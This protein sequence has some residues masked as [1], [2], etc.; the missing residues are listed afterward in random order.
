MAALHDYLRFDY[1]PGMHHQLHWQRT[2]TPN[3]QHARL[4]VVK[5]RRVADSFRP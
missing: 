3:L 1:A 5:A 2:L 4:H